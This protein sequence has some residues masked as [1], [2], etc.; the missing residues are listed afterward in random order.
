MRN[1]AEDWK[2]TPMYDNFILEYGKASDCINCRRC[3]NNCPQKLPI[4]QHL[5]SIAQAFEKT[6]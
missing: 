3:E 6:E 2:I 5:K 4:T 1:P